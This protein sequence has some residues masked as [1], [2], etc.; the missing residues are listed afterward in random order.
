MVFQEVLKNDFVKEFKDMG[1]ENQFSYKGLS[2]L[3]E[4]LDENMDLYELD[5]IELCTQFTEY[6]NIEDFMSEMLDEEDA[7]EIRSNL[8]AVQLDKV[9]EY[10]ESKTSIVCCEPDCILFGSF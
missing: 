10:L 5:V 1:R 9:Q 2:R 4:Y 3:Y 7:Q 8:Y 6:T